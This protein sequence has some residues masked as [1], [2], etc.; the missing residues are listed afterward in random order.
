[1]MIQSIRRDPIRGRDDQF[2]A[3]EF[4]V[5]D[6]A[7]LT[8]RILLNLFRSPLVSVPI[9]LGAATWAAGLAMGEPVGFLSFLGFLGVSMGIGTGLTKLVLF[10]KGMTRCTFQNVWDDQ[11]HTQDSYLDQLDERLAADND[12][13]TNE[14]I[15]ELRRQRDR[16]VNSELIN[17]H[18]HSKILPEIKSNAEKLFHSCLN[19]LERSLVFW[20]AANQMATREARQELLDSR[21]Q[22]LDEIR[23]SVCLLGM[24]LDCLHTSALRRDDTT[25]LAQIR[26]ELEMG[27]EVAQRVEQRMM[28]IENGL[29][30]DDDSLRSTRET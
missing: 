8:K 1:M 18:A 30:V 25:D 11:D 16:L 26:Q 24:S 2:S 9:A 14:Y 13:R 3:T 5:M 12:P 15:A 23:N 27:L 28:Q 29:D 17:N 19:S 6:R 10:T 21:E 20:D 7:A 4:S 22:L